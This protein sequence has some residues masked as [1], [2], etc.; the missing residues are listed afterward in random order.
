ML[1]IRW[2]TALNLAVTQRKTALGHYG[3]ELIG[4]NLEAIRKAEDR[5]LFKEAMERIGVSVCPSASPHPGGG[6][7]GGGGHRIPPGDP[8]CLHPG[9]LRWGDRLQPGGIGAICKS[10]LE[11]SR[12]QILIE[13]S[14]LGG[15]EFELEVMRDNVDNVVI[16]CWIENLDPMGVHTGDSIPSLP[17]K[18]SLI[19]N[20]SGFVIRL[21]PSFERSEWIRVAATFNLPLIPVDGE[22][23]VI[24]MNPRVSPLLGLRPARR[25]DFLSLRLPHA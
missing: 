14:L 6:S 13:Q 9:R 17:P 8:A 1:P 21:L 24:E 15:K 5:L 25:R 7:V 3:V 2:Q 18:H 19:G 20:T 16:V 11:A 12:F 4:A 22:V 10:G 23:V